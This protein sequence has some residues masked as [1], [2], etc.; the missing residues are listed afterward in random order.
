V[1]VVQAVVHRAPMLICLIDQA[2]EPACGHFLAVI[3]PL[4]TLLEKQQQEK[5]QKESSSILKPKQGW[6]TGW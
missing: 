2:P 5:S 6:K 3:S 1:E 4:P